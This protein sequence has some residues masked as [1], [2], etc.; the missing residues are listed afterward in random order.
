MSFVQAALSEFE[1]EAATTRRLLERIPD[2][3]LG[4]KP[5]SK[6]MS[7]ARLASHLAEIPEWAEGALVADEFDM[8][9]PGGEM[10]QTK[11]YDSVA[12]LL[13]G[14]DANVEK[15]KKA[16][17]S[18][19]DAAMGD[20]WSLKMQGATIFAMPRSAVIRIWVLNHLVHHRGQL[21]VFLRLNDIPVPSIYGPSA[22]EQS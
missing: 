17:S 6:S 19:D 9:P 18:A 2:D 21:S 5:H 15:A 20:T 22:D 12:A 14:F 10:A 16:L 11:T 13:E 3:K 8:H 1:N 7:M 4:W